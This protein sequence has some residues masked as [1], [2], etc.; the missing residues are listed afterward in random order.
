MPYVTIKDPDQIEVIAKKYRNIVVILTYM[1]SQF[2]PIALI[3]AKTPKS[4]GCSEC[5]RV[6]QLC[7]DIFSFV[8][9]YIS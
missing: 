7:M 1:Y 3:T 4:F 6:K 5:K 2:N 8:F 9:F